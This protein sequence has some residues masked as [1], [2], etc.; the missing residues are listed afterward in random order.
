MIRKAV[1]VFLLVTPLVLPLLPFLNS[2]QEQK[3][4]YALP[5]GADLGRNIEFLFSL[6]EGVDPETARS[7]AKAVFQALTA[8]SAEILLRDTIPSILERIRDDN[9]ITDFARTIVLEELLTSTAK[10][11]GEEFL[12]L[13]RELLGLLL[14]EYNKSKSGKGA[15]RFSTQIDENDI[16]VLGDDIYA[17]FCAAIAAALQKEGQ[18]PTAQ[19]WNLK[20]QFLDPNIIAFPSPTSASRSGVRADIYFFIFLG[21]GVLFYLWLLATDMLSLKENALLMT[22]VLP[23]KIRRYPVIAWTVVSQVLF[24]VY[25]AAQKFLTGG[26]DKIFF[27]LAL[28]IA[29]QILIWGY[30]KFYLDSGT[31]WEALQDVFHLGQGWESTLSRRLESKKTSLAFGFAWAIVVASFVSAVAFESLW[32][33]KVITWLYLFYVNF[34]TGLAVHEILVIS[35]SIISLR[36]YSFKN[37]IGNQKDIFLLGTIILKI[38]ICLVLY[39]CICLGS[40]KMTGFKGIDTYFSLYLAVSVVGLIAFFFGIP[41]FI[42]QKLRAYRIT[43][44]SILKKDLGVKIAASLSEDARNLEAVIDLNKKYSGIIK[45]FTEIPSWPFNFRIV[46]SFFSVIL[47]PI[48]M[49]IFNLLTS[50]DSIFYHLD[51]VQKLSQLFKK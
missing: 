28:V 16:A 38:A 1:L 11:G 2:T 24:F 33:M 50:T 9:K 35:L 49:I 26:Y 13:R 4:D 29:T 5:F 8:P 30:Y 48:F 31:L 18:G 45:E 47:I 46:S 25:A 23:P 19:Y 40:F 27:P 17:R 43:H 42:H 34:W 14:E 36:R 44:T 12:R 7:H 39:I 21:F 22:S 32:T 3:D 6:R 41:F 10:L 20:A 51:A 37:V 15:V